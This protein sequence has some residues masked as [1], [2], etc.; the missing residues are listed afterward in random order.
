[1]HALFEISAASPKQFPT[2]EYPEFAFVGR[3]NVGK[4][5]LLNLLTG[6]RGLAKVS[7]TP[8]KTRQINFFLIDG[9]RRF[10]DLPGYGYARASKSDRADW[11]R[12]ITAY[13]EQQRPVALVLQLIDS[14]LTLQS[15]DA[16]V[17]GWFVERS[18]PLQ[19]VLTKIDKLKQAE[20][21]KHTRELQAAFKDIGYSGDLLMVSSVKGHGKKELLQRIAQTSP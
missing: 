18:L 5:S 3:S 15:S 14:R 10:V 6:A 2:P 1:M 13:F 9:V 21:V 8:G 19:I 11:G 17:L 20:R 12:L 7:S 4:S 16:S